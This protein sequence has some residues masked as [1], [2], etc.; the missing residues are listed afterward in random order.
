MNNSFHLLQKPNRNVLSLLIGDLMFEID[1][2]FSYALKFFWGDWRIGR[3]K[4]PSYALWC[5]PPSGDFYEIKDD[6]D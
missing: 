6:Q 1:H 2:S 5:A 3:N 4:F